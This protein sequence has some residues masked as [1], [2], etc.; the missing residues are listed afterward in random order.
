MTSSV[1]LI[2]RPATNL[3]QQILSQVKVWKWY[4]KTPDFVSSIW[5]YILIK[6]K[7]L[8]KAKKFIKQEKNKNKKLEKKQKYHE[9]RSGGLNVGLN[10]D[11][12][13]SLKFQGSG[14]LW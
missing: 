7:K 6:N 9:I 14:A 4:L 1:F 10:Q 5:I 12:G 8:K 13:L 3:G 2:S 11:F